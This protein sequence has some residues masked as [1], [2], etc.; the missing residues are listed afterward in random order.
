MTENRENKDKPEKPNEK[1][2]KGIKKK[3]RISKKNKKIHSET[4]KF[5][6]KMLED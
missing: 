1:R 4:S 3:I 2:K 5:I 6:T